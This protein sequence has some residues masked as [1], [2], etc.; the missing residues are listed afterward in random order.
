MIEMLF[1]K[2]STRIGCPSTDKRAYIPYTEEVKRREGKPAKGFFWAENVSGFEDI[3]D[4]LKT[5]SSL[6]ELQEK[7]LEVQVPSSEE[8]DEGYR[9]EAIKITANVRKTYR[10]DEVGSRYTTIEIVHMI[11][12]ES[13]VP[14]A[15]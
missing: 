9:Y 1:F 3:V 8:L 5:S 6:E 10:D 11:S 14:K 4:E 2:V 13:S 15:K 7:L 12:K